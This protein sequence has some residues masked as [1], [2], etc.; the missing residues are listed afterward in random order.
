MRNILVKTHSNTFNKYMH[1]NQRN[2]RRTCWIYHCIYIT[3]KIALVSRVY[4]INKYS[5]PLYRS[6]VKAY[7]FNSIH[8]IQSVRKSEK[9]Q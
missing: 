5:R 4:S 3:C 6:G 7:D 9:Q 8:S 1:H 2:C